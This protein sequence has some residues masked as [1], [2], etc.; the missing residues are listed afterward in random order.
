MQELMIVPLGWI[1]AFF[2]NATVFSS[3]A[4]NIKTLVHRSWRQA[5]QANSE[6]HTH[7]GHRLQG[8]N[9]QATDVATR[10]CIDP[11]VTAVTR[12]G[13]GSLTRTTSVASQR[14][15][16]LVVFA[17][18]SGGTTLD[19]DRL[20]GNPFAS[21]LIELSGKPSLTLESLLSELRVLTG[22]FSHG[23]QHVEWTGNLEIG[24][25]S[26][27]IAP[28]ERGEHRVALALVV[29]DYSLAGMPVLSGAAHDERRVA[30]MLA[31]NGFSVD[32]G[33]GPERS[34]LLKALATLRTRSK[35]SDVTIA[36]ATGHGVE[37]DGHVYLLPADYPFSSGYSRALLQTRAVAITRI[38][39]AMRGALLNI[40]FFAG[41]R[42][43]V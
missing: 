1:Y 6:A 29:S 12:A 28:G 31:A 3:S 18:T 42:T 43:R 8:H 38:V 27:P 4:P 37:R 19:R 13:S 24:N 32:Q 33:V 21:A 11:L 17:T 35:G 30:T 16:S 15:K 5:R 40:V 39:N 10:R 20:G 14:P 26:F 9:E 7:Q 22:Q 2:S 41:C 36:Y 34:E 23:H 25:W